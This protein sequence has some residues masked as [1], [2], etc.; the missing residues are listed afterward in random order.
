MHKLLCLLAILSLV[1]VPLQAAAS[2]LDAVRQ[3]DD[4]RVAATIAA[5]R[6]R[7]G[8]IFSDDL[9]YRHSSGVVNDKAAY[10]DVIATG[11]TKYFSIAYE[12]RKFK[13]VAPGIVLM[14]GRCHIKSA[15]DGKTL[16]HYLGFLAVWRLE[17]G[18]WR[19]LAWQ[20]VG[21]PTATAAH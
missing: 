5:D 10:I 9:E 19:F 4:E 13:P 14:T 21:L 1:C 6:A 20:S 18:A 8:A 16:D 3:A 17:A 12:E 2:D 15:N 11:R 7:L